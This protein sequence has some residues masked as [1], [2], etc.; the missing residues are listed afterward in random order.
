MSTKVY[1][2]LVIRRG[3]KTNLPE[4]LDGEFL[5]AEDTKELFL[6]T[7]SNGNIK[8]NQGYTPAS[9]GHWNGNPTNYI[10]A[11]DRLAAAVSGLL[12][13]PIP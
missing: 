12:G 4:G 10:D 8:P 13:G 2:P 11:I 7:S 3:V 9:P 1:T 5:F 6:G